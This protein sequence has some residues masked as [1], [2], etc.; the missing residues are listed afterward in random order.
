MSRSAD[1]F[2]MERTWISVF[3][4]M[5]RI[6]ILCYRYRLHTYGFSCSQ[7][8]DIVS[9]KYNP[10]ALTSAWPAVSGKFSGWFRLEPAEHP[11]R[12]HDNM[13]IEKTIPPRQLH[14]LFRITGN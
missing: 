2:L 9:T 13:G 8:T 3:G 14:Y 12:L 6:Q 1:L 5:I 11:H 4:I 7:N 10:Q